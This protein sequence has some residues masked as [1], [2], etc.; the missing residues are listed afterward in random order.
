MSQEALNRGIATIRR[1]YESSAKRGRITTG[2]V[3]RCMALIT[4]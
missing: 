3:E 1:N 4:P 2:E